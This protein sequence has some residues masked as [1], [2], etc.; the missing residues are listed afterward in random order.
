[1][2]TRKVRRLSSPRLGRAAFV[3]L[4]VVVGILAVCGG[5]AVAGVVP[6]FA[7][8]EGLRR[9][10]DPMAAVTDTPRAP[11]CAELPDPRPPTGEVP[12]A[13]AGT[14]ELTEAQM[15]ALLAA[16]GDGL[17]DAELSAIM[18]DVGLDPGELERLRSN[19]ERELSTP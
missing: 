2:S 15:D 10:L 11:E 17:D 1:M 12:L 5:I 13:E 4:I 18:E 6:L 14:L 7:Q 8:A 19:L 9:C 3:E 16:A